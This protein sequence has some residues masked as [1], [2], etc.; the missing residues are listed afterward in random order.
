MIRLRAR[1]TEAEKWV[2]DVKTKWHPGEGFFT[3]SSSE[4]IASEAKS[5]HD[6]DIG[7]AIQAL[8]F[9]KNR[10]S[11]QGSDIISKINKAVELLQKQK[12]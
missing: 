7:K 1:K 10:N 8:E 2:G 6:G 4:K 9:A 3:D 12:K 5:G 11:S